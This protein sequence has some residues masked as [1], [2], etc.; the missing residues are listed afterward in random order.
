MLIITFSQL[1]SDRLSTRVDKEQDIN[2][3]LS[4]NFI[5][6]VTDL[7]SSSSFLLGTEKIIYFSVFS[8]KHSCCP[9]NSSATSLIMK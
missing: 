8:P 7:P 6:Y 4:I 5:L 3:K 9:S 2:L 1:I